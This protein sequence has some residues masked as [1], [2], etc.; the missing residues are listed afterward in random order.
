MM[1]AAVEHALDAWEGFY[2]IVGG[3]GAALTGLQF[4]VMTLIDGAR[5]RGH[6]S[7]ATNPDPSTVGA[8]GT[9]TVVHFCAALLIA[10]ILTAPWESVGGVRTALVLTGAAGLAYAVLIT[11]RARR[12]TGY[13]PVLEDWLF[14]SLFP[15]AAYGGIVAGATLLRRDIE[16]ALFI[17]SAMSMLLLF[18]GI[19]NAWD[20]VTYLLLGEQQDTPRAPASS[21]TPPRPRSQGGRNRRRR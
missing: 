21:P 20:T 7:L 10:G 18:I 11:V 17:V 1:Q 2:L 3:A 14:H 16:D 15:I 6:G 4:V 5:N 13:K 19:H 9:P 12:Q 8:F